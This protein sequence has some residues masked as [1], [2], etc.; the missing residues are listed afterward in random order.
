VFASWAS[1][2]D[3]RAATAGAT[4]GFGGPRVVE[5][6]TGV[7]PPDSSHTAESAYAAG[8]VDAVIDPENGGRWLAA[9]VGIEPGAPLSLE[10][11]RPP[12]RSGVKH[13]EDAWELLVRTRSTRRPSGVEW[14][15][16]LTESWVEMRGADPCVRAGLARLSGAP[17]VVVAMDRTAAARA[18]RLPGPGAFRLAQ[19]A[20]QYADRVGL[21]LLTLVDTPGAD[22]A[23][24]SEAAGVAG[25]IAR[26]LLEMS[27]L[28]TRSVCLVV[29]EGGSGGAMALAHA[30]QLLVLAGATFEVIGPEA[31]ATV[32]YR[33]AARAPDFARAVHITPRH[34]MDLGVADAVLPERS[35]VVRAAV[36]A[37]LSGHGSSGRHVRADR[38]TSRALQPERPDVHR[39]LRRVED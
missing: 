27:R 33:D 12:V 17:V 39:G 3:F 34:L 15:A 6:V 16:E 20:I 13:P 30:D 2:A 35:A 29:G 22:P 5:Q 9:A 37:A 38:A 23:P 25:E 32:L 11:W 28:R 1:L 24:P 26:T 8:I 10:Q 21:P 4:V 18:G 36:S 7:R 19:R 14:A 31:G